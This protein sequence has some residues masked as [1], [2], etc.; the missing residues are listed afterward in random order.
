MVDRYVNPAAPDNRAAVSNKMN[1]RVSEA[2]RSTAA[3]TTNYAL[4]ITPSLRV[5]EMNMAKCPSVVGNLMLHL[6]WVI[7]APRSRTLT[8]SRYL[9]HMTHRVSQTSPG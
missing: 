1:I 2:I 5:E 3:S 8:P 7:A 6:P 9:V 4:D